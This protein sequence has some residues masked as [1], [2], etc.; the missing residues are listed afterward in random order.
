[1]STPATESRAPTRRTAPVIE[2][3]AVFTLDSLKHT[4]GLARNCLP[5][6]IRLARL[7]AAKRAGRYFLLGKW[8]LEWIEDGE[9]KRTAKRS[10]IDREVTT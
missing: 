10:V 8:V 2:P 3:N 5:R 4:L 6:E 1:M 7:R 9:L